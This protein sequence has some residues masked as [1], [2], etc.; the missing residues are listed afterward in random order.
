MTRHLL[1]AD[2]ACIRSALVHLRQAHAQLR[3][4]KVRRAAILT[5]QAIKSTEG[6]ERALEAKLIP[7]GG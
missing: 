6:A 5:A 4:A 2:L 3:H 1:L 7:N